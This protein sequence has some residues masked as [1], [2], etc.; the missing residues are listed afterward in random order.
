MIADQ[1]ANH[2]SF[3]WLAIGIDFKDGEADRSMILGSSEA[4]FL[5]LEILSHDCAVVHRRST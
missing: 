3:N 2:T 4:I 5:Q 1:S